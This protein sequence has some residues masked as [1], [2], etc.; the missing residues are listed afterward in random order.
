[1]IHVFRRFL[2]LLLGPAGAALGSLSGLAAH[3]LLSRSVRYFWAPWLGWNWLIGLL[4][5][6]AIGFLIAIPFVSA[7]PGGPMRLRSDE[8]RAQDLHLRM[9]I[10]AF[11]AAYLPIGIG[12]LYTRW[13]AAPSLPLPFTDVYLYAGSRGDLMT[14]MVGIAVLGPFCAFG[15]ERLLRGLPR[16]LRLL[17][18]P[19]LAAI[20]ATGGV[21]AASLVAGALTATWAQGEPYVPLLQ[22]LAQHGWDTG[23][24]LALLTVVAGCFTGA[25]AAIGIGLPALAGLPDPTPSASRRRWA[26]PVL[27]VALS[28]ALG[29]GAMVHGYGA[30]SVRG[31]DRK[32]EPGITELVGTLVAPADQDILQLH[33]ENG[34]FYLFEFPRPGSRGRHW[35]A[36]P[37]Y[38]LPSGRADRL[39]YLIEIPEYTSTTEVTVQPSWPTRT[40]VSEYSGTVRF[41]HVPL[42][43]Q[44]SLTGRHELG[45]GPGQLGQWTVDASEKPT[46]LVLDPRV[47]T[48]WTFLAGRVGY[49]DEW[50]YTPGW[51][52][53]FL[54]VTVDGQEVHSSV[55]GDEGGTFEGETVLVAQTS[56]GEDA[57]QVS[58]W[59]QPATRP[60]ETLTIPVIA[61]GL[62]PGE[63]LVH[64]RLGLSVLA[65]GGG[66]RLDLLPEPGGAFASVAVHPTNPAGADLQIR[67]MG[68]DG[69]WHPL[70]DSLLMMGETT[71]D[72][73]GDQE[74][75]AAL[76]L[77]TGAGNSGTTPALQGFGGLLPR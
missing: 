37:G 29:F 54:R 33:A 40:G 1:M 41:E 62:A 28:G 55:L 53:V 30:D 77:G 21:L 27:A 8:G 17:L 23:L 49:T 7:Y 6:P 5:Y 2:P 59:L 71:L 11:V 56:P 74:G 3:Q 13:W 73:A 72:V 42:W 38:E 9:W 12:V 65:V 14:V 32:I 67:R 36:I 16:L 58:V 31:I 52:V 57:P 43:T 22:P 46:E 34:G 64:A 60:G 68:D 47:A 20:L 45:V 4:V 75:R 18:G 35:V 26:L 61:Q 19:P 51:S 10:A 69:A 50:N 70:E 48:R 44:D 63:P 25:F 39:R 66:E 24:M 76:V 15:V